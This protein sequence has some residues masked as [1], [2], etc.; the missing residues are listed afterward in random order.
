MRRALLLVLALL[1]CCGLVQSDQVLD[2]SPYPLKGVGREAAVHLVNEVVLQEFHAL[3]GG[4]YETKI[5]RKTDTMEVTWAGDES[6]TLTLYVN[7]VP[8]D[9]E[10]I[11]EMLALVRHVQVPGMPGGSRMPPQ[12]DLI[13]EQQLYDAFV[14]EAVKRGAAQHAEAQTSEADR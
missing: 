7:F 11:V 8:G 6:R 4:G 2:F 3:F 12:K 10:T 9:G 5:D 13:L 14:L 1:P